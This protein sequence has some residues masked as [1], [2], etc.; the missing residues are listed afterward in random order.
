MTYSRTTDTRLVRSFLT[1]PR[2]WRR[3]AND[4]APKI[5]DFQVKENPDITYVVGVENRAIAEALFLLCKSDYGPKTAEVHFC[6]VP[7]VWGRSIE[8]AAGFLRWVWK[9]TNLNR[10]IGKL[11]SYNRLAKK[12]AEAVGFRQFGIKKRAGTRRGVTFDLLLLDLRRP[13]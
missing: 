6:L 3:M 8:V 2:L 12:L 1:D 11:P 4:D 13:A 9:N 10:L 7:D 5:N